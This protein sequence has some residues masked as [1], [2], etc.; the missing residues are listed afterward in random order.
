[1]ISQVNLSTGE[2]IGMEALVRWD[3]PEHGGI[4]LMEFIPV[5][6]ESGLEPKYLEVEITENVMQNSDESLVILKELKN[7]GV[8]LAIDDFG[9]GY[10]SLSRLINLPIDTLKIDKS[11]EYK[12][13]LWRCKWIFKILIIID[14]H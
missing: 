2:I 10:S 8:K 9:V 11:S 3:H 6:E 14:C 12:K 7:V 13:I 5:A 4:F 1:M